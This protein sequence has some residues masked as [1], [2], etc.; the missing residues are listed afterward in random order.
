MSSS[1][2]ARVRTSVLSAATAAVLGAALAAVPIAAVPAQAGAVHA[3]TST[4]RPWQS[5]SL[6]PQVVTLVTGDRVLVRHD[7]SGHTLASLTPSSPHYGQPVQ[8]VHTPDHTWVMPKLPRRVR[9]RFDPSVFD[10]AALAGSTHVRL[11]VTFARGTAPR[12]LPGLGLR[13]D[14]SRTLPSGRTTAVATYDASRALPASLA[15]SLRGVSKISLARPAVAPDPGYTLQTLTIDATS[16]KGQPLAD[17]SVFVM[18]ADDGR[19]FDAMGGIVDGQWKVAVP[20]GHYFVVVSTFN[21]VVVDQATVG[22]ADAET[23]MTMADAT[24]RP[25][26]KAPPGFHAADPELQITGSDETGNSGFGFGFS[27][28]YPLVSPVSSV[29]AGSLF[30]ELSDVWT[31]KKYRPITFHGSTITKHPIKRVAAA[32]RL[33]K[34]IPR[35][36][37]FGYRKKDYADVTIKHSATGPK[38]LAFDGWVAFSPVDQGL[39]VT[40][41]P[42]VRPGVI[43]ASFLAD[44]RLVWDSST[45]IDDNPGSFTELDQTAKYRAGQHAVVHF[46]RGPVTPVADVGGESKKVSYACQLCVID[47]TL[48]GSLAMMSSAGS[49]QVG[50]NDHG[51][52]QVYRGAHLLNRGNTLL[53]PFVPGVKPGQR[54]RMLA[55]TSPPDK[56]YVLSDKVSDEW[57]FKIPS[58]R[59]AIV[60][61]LRAAYVP[62]TTMKGVGK[63]GSVSYPITFDNLGPVDSRVRKAKVAWSLDGEHWH[64]A[65]LK[66][67]DKNAFRVSYRQPAATKGHPY[68][69]LRVQA[70]DSIGG[71]I[72]EVVSHAY[73]LPHGSPKHHRTTPTKRHRTFHP[74]RLCRTSGKHGYS[75]FVKLDRRTR[76]A[77]RAAPDPAGLGATDLRSAYD[78]GADSG[79]PDTVAVIDAFGYPHAEADMNAYRAQYG[80]PPCTTASG[81]FTKLNQDGDAG[82]YPPADYDWGVETALDLQMISTACP[83]CHIV[84]VEANQPSDA[85]FFASEQTAVDAG[86]LVTSH[87][88]GRIELT[89]AEQDALNY[90]HPGVTA[91]ASTGDDSYGPAH[92]P[93]SSPDVV[94]VGGTVLSPSG[95]SPRGW[96]ETAWA[97]GSSGCS[98]YFAKPAGQNDA[99]CHGRTVS[100]ISAAASGIAVYDTSLPK[101][102]RGWLTVDGT[103]ASAPL[104]A[105]MVAST[106]AA[107]LRPADL[108]AESSDAFNDVV[109][110]SNG[111]CRGSYMCT[112]VPGYDAPTGLG[113]PASPAALDPPS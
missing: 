77:G 40:T 101:R 36:L 2:A 98:A 64:A 105:G 20:P 113:T 86:A 5:Q 1:S 4:A 26:T 44:K 100:D 102:Y 32:K 97:G 55:F 72:R 87:S 16:A 15:S 103:S 65:H 52:F 110:G 82:H 24:V 85:S 73:V 59:R 107:G 63:S 90:D 60:P 109:S 76:S 6:R 9:G 41:F 84:L 25:K 95:S 37:T 50:L 104:I 79:T 11:D 21:R 111:F 108:Y 12:S 61:M 23:A 99:A 45:T 56:N 34:G 89:G 7:A 19:L 78:I 53:S 17:S 42:S 69:S 83:T 14:T 80:L 3:D 96:T 106:G 67:R 57:W 94:A 39:M 112:G 10:V 51:R 47:G 58:G 29:P 48:G 75:C 22:D 62:P 68:L 91:V 81:C 46:F 71:K 28:A 35:H 8:F 92:F 27:G 93:A 66:R 18:N 33:L 70:S 43:H 54:L 74:G 13:R 31:P 49:D 30:T 88:F 38:Q